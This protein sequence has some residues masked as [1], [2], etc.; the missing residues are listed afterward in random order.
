MPGM[1]HLIQKLIKGSVV[2][3]QLTPG[4]NRVIS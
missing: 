4:S 1:A 3:A 2:V